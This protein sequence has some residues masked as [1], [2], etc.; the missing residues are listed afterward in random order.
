MIVFDTSVIVPLFLA[1]H[2]KHAR[3]R[4]AFRTHKDAGIVAPLWRSELRS[5]L[6]K[7]VAAAKLTLDDAHRTFDRAQSIFARI[8]R[9]PDARTVLHLALERGVSSYDA[10]HL[11]LAVAGGGMVLTDDHRT[12]AKRVPEYCITLGG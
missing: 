3:A 7:Y 9:E 1:V 2:D 12:L 6:L 4:R 8:E 5:A 10:E 11:A